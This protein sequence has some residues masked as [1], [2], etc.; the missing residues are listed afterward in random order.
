MFSFFSD[1][2]EAPDQKQDVRKRVFEPAATSSILK[3]KGS[4]LAVERPGKGRGA[5]TMRAKEMTP[6]ALRVESSDL[7]DV[8]LASLKIVRLNVIF[9]DDVKHNKESGYNKVRQLLDLDDPRSESKRRYWLYKNAVQKDSSR[10][11]TDVLLSEEEDGS[12]DTS[13]VSVLDDFNKE[14][15]QVEQFIETV[16]TR[17]HL[18]RNSH[19]GGSLR[20]VL[21]VFH[22][23][24]V[25]VG[26]DSNQAFEIVWKTVILARV[27]NV[28]LAED[29]SLKVLKEMLSKTYLRKLH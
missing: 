3:P 28:G 25:A 1:P 24:C 23:A 2:G 9:E 13:P 4:P 29:G 10:I 19:L 17:E 21:R 16:R 8:E 12:E 27:K 26:V 14:E 18:D 22:D 6:P 15:R 20:D 11:I 5:S 7:T